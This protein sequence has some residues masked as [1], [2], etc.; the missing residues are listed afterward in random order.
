MPASARIQV[1]ST[2]CC[3]YSSCL[4]TAQ[5]L[6][7]SRHHLVKRALCKRLNMRLCSSIVYMRRGFVQLS[8]IPQRTSAGMSSSSA[9]CGAG[10]AAPLPFAWG[11]RP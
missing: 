8:E 6:R 2:L 9:A 5:K 7:H 10:G 4:C 3:T 11:G 1:M